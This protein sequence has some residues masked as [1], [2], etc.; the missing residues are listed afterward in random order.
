[1]F[2]RAL[3]LMSSKK[4]PYVKR[5]LGAIKFTKPNFIKVIN[6]IKRNAMPNKYFK[7]LAFVLPF[8]N[9]R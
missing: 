7:K 5:K 8:H 9:K 2:L 6:K 4:I 3:F 1:M